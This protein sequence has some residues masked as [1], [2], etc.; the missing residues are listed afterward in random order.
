MLEWVSYLV[1]LPACILCYLPMRH[2]LRK[3]ARF[4][5]ISFLVYS[6]AVVLPAEYLQIRLDANPNIFFFGLLLAAALY[7]VWSV[8]VPV[9]KSLA[10]IM[11][12]TA[13]LSILSN[14]A[15]L[16]DAR[17]HPELGFS[18]SSM[19]FILFQSAAGF[20]A[21]L[22]L[23]YPCAKL[24]AKM[25]DTIHVN[26]AWYM[27]IPFSAVLLA[28]NLVIRPERYSTIYFNRVGW[29]I[30]IILFLM[31]AAW[32]IADLIFYIISIGLTR[33]AEILERNRVFEMQEKQY[34]DQMRYLE[35]SA[36]DRHDF[37]Q[38][39]L[40]MKGLAEAGDLEG[41]NAYLDRFIEAFPQKNTTLYCRDSALNG[42]LNYYAKEA[43]EAGI[44]LNWKIDPDFVQQAMTDETGKNVPADSPAAAGDGENFR[45]R[46]GIS[47]VDLSRVIGNLLDNALTAAKEGPE[48]RFI[49]LVI[50]VR[51][52]ILYIVMTN[53][54]D[55]RV[56][57]ENGRYESVH[58]HGRGTGLSSVRYIVKH[59]GGRTS[60]SHEGKEFYSNVL[61]P[62][63]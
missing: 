50:R 56:R 1:F 4:I 9:C 6:A 59:Y 22:L 44:H 26:Q 33:N 55:G 11:N 3:S 51:G 29:A 15:G 31:L 18:N 7:Y 45:S 12:V 21:L 40:A 46:C 34:H 58:G 17:L 10:V 41:L 30:R 60:F 2:Q 8:K 37:R 47:V 16:Y 63:P 48:H 61:I 54:F 5:V 27:T 62:L 24:G 53:S 14:F 57:K 25:V 49:Q 43:K 35:E 42:I 39:I 28:M 20:V 23:A 13:L 52:R 36:R 19:D 38:M 32:G